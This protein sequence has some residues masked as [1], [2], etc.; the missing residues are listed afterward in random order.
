MKKNTVFFAYIWFLLFSFA[1]SFAKNKTQA[2]TQN[3]PYLPIQKVAYKFNKDPIDVVIVCIVKDARTLDMCIEGIKKN[4][5]NIRRVI[6]ISPEKL[7]AKAE[8]FDEAKFPFSKKDLLRQLFKDENYKLDRIG[9]IYQQLLKLYSPFVIPNISS[10]ILLLDAD[11]IFLNPV[12]FCDKNTGAGFFNPGKEFHPPYFNHG[13]KL[14]PGFKRVFSEYSGISHHMLVQRCILEDMFLIVEKKF[15]IS[16]WEA[17]C[18]C[19][20]LNDVEG[21]CASEYELY[22]NFTLLRTNQCEI[23]KLKWINTKLQNLELFK[24]KGYHYVSCH[25]YLG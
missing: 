7:T 2:L 12:M 17:F 5:S 6:V 11:T 16:F 4:A 19:I 22:F 3:P 18:N 20:D 9:W 25:S 14:I 23:R 15:K 24:N 8:W 1:S 13:Q 21:A 10:N